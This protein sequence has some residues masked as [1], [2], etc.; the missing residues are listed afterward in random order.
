MNSVVLTIITMMLCVDSSLG[1]TP[2][3]N[4][5]SSS[6]Q[7]QENSQ[8]PERYY[9]LPS[10]YPP[11]PLQYVDSSLGMTPLM[12]ADSSSPQ[13]QENSQLPQGSYPSPLYYPPHSLQCDA[14]SLGMTSLTNADS[15]S[16]QNQENSQLTQG[17][18]PSPSYYPP[19]P[20][21]CVDSSSGMTP[22]TN[23]DAFSPQNQENS[24]LPEG[25]YPSP[26]YYPPNPLQV[27]G[28]A[29]M[30]PIYYSFSPR[31][32]RSGPDIHTFDSYNDIKKLYGSLTHGI[33]LALART[34]IDEYNKKSGSQ[35][36]L[37]RRASRGY[38]ALHKELNDHWDVLQEFLVKISLEFH[39]NEAEASG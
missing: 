10:Y 18:Y 23:A 34:L 30:P 38:Y 27:E 37:S 4:A 36:K 5:D 35:L 32:Y 9:P 8:L 39:Y 7:N 3:T 1:M 12:N 29:P 26:L 15:S 22:L 14:S 24:Q 19:N 31:R 11:N 21:Q 17:S 2:L 28:M 33:L 25:Y 13:N 20:I 16:P 6:P